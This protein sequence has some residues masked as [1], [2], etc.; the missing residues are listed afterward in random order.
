MTA[1]RTAPPAF[2]PPVKQP[3][4]S[5]AAST[6]FSV[7]G[8]RRPGSVDN[9]ATSMGLGEG[10]APRISGQDA[11]AQSIVARRIDSEADFLGV[12]VGDVIEINV[13]LLND[14]PRGARLLYRHSEVDG[15]AV[16]LEENGQDHNA[17][18]W[19]QDGKA[20]VMDG[21]KR[22]RGARARGQATL[23]A[24][25]IKAPDNLLEAWLESRRLNLERSDH[26]IY[27]D[28]V[29]FK[30]MLDDGLVAS[31][32]ELA[33]KVSPPGGPA[34]TQGYISQILS[35]ADIP[36][37]FMAKLVEYPALCTKNAAYNIARLF[38]AETKPED[39]EATKVI[40]QVLAAAQ[41]NPDVTASEVKSIIEKALGNVKQRASSTAV[42]ARA[43]RFEGRLTTI[44]AKGLV[45]LEFTNV[46]EADLAELRALLERIDVKAS[47]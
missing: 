11:A 44:P 13:R 20:Y 33:E 26:T 34:R 32:Q 38:A 37:H 28:A 18:V 4:A 40:D 16:S 46:P 31:Q 21:G 23:R 24:D 1:K 30:D 9:L 25:V 7:A 36:R 15:T 29:R 27:D 3:Q 42:V 41:A 43:G 45:R 22:L 10:Q 47:Q 19:I 35:I 5:P 14:N 8:L 17:K 39:E 2:K 6:G 12:N